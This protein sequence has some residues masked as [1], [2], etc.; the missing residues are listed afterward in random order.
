MRKEKELRSNESI[1]QSGEKR[2]LSD[3]FELQPPEFSLEY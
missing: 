1:Y 3:C 2:I